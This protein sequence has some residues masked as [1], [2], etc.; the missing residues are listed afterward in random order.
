MKTTFLLF[1]A[2]I[3]M[4]LSSCKKGA[5]G[6]RG[7]KGEPGAP[8]GQA[9]SFLYTAQ[10]IA[11]TTDLGY[12]EGSGMQTWSGSK[13]FIPQGYTA[14]VNNGIVLVYF[15]SGAND[16]WHLSTMTTSR[17][18]ANESVSTNVYTAVLEKDKIRINAVSRSVFTDGQY[19]N[20]SKFDLKVVV[21]KAVAVPEVSSHVN[22][23]SLAEV[24]RYYGLK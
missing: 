5:Q 3:G 15:R 13:D 24:E 22:V 14:A 6:P 21:I 2:I 4:S 19:L 20:S 7:E 16:G 23:N 12:D 9:S 1:T 11:P 8:A 18:E 10:E 17:K